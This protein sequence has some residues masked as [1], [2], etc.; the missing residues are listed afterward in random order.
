M[1]QGNR[2]GRKGISNGDTECTKVR[3]MK[4]LCG[5]LRDASAWEFV[6]P[7]HKAQAGTVAERLGGRPRQLSHLPCHVR[8]LNFVLQMT[9]NQ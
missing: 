6:S 3:D 5:V 7:G 2:V 8:N 1:F 4:Q 9:G